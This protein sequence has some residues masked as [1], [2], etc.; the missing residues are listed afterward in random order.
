MWKGRKKGKHVLN[1]K[2]LKFG[3]SSFKNELLFVNELFTFF[4]EKPNITKHQQNCILS[5][6]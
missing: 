6:K 2:C 4:S 1:K 3:E 5:D